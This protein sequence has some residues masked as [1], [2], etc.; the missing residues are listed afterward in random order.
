VRAGTVIRAQRGVFYIPE[1][2]GTC[3]PAEDS[4]DT[5]SGRELATDSSKAFLRATAEARAIAHRLPGSA[6]SHVSASTALTLPAPLGSADVGHVTLP[7]ARPR[8]SGL[9]R[10]HSSPL[11]SGHVLML[12]DLRLTTPAR[13]AIDIA[14]TSSL[15]EALICMDAV[16]RGYVDRAREDA[17]PLRMAVHDRHLVTA[18][19]QSL[20]TTLLD[21]QGWPGVRGARTA[22]SW[23]DPASESPLESHSRGVLREAGIEPPVCGFPVEGANGMTY[24][25]DMV[26]ETA[27]VIGECDGLLKYSEPSVLHREKLRQEA[28]ERAG[29][30]IIRWTYADIMRSPAHVVERVVHALTSRR[31]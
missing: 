18:A 29:W 22:L 12:G 14:R 7:G 31:Q 27:G 28:L 9:V 8:M 26:W 15:P 20:E 25:A 13:T 24:W 19:R 2:P 16:M 21:M 10:I 6:I 5:L 17:L 30:R 4:G 23:A 1:T 3:W 11:P